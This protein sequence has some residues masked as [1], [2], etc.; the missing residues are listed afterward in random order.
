MH[1]VHQ[2]QPTRERELDLDEI[3]RQ[4]ARKMLAQAL[5]AEV[6]AYLRAAEGARDERGRALVVRN[7]HA[8]S[9]EVICGAG[10]RF[11]SGELVERNE[12]KYAA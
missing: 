10:A 8:R 12:E 4:G 11:V 9:R 3:T 6:N 2:D 1:S 5:E 7:G